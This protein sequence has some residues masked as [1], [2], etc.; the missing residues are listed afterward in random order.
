MIQ[1]TNRIEFLQQLKNHL[2][3]KCRAVEIGVLY[4][5]FAQDIYD[6][7]N[8]SELWLIDPWQVNDTKYGLGL[9]TAYSTDADYN[10]VLDRF[11]HQIEAKRV[12]IDARYSYDAVDDY[13]DGYF[14]FIYIDGSHLYEDV[15]IDL[16]DWLPKVNK[17]GYLCGHDYINEPQFGV[18][19]AVDEFIAI[20]NLS[21][22]ILNTIGGDFA[23]QIT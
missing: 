22:Q 9:S 20:N 23:I 21:I 2:P 4:G 13:P 8:P 12:I 14:D 10:Q 3:D 19:Q 1:I 6:A 5:A 16:N 15:K 11:K 17:G 18:I 7:F